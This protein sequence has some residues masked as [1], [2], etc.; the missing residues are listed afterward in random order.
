LSRVTLIADHPFVTVF[1][2]VSWNNTTATVKY[3]ESWRHPNVGCLV[4]V[5]M[6][7]F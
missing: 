7:G 4:K 1:V 2:S 5:R 3:G 6:V